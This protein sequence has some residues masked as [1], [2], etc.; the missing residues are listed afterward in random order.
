MSPDIEIAFL[1]HFA[2][3]L[4]V[5]ADSEV[6]LIDCIWEDANGLDITI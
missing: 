4:K 5:I 1:Q 2:L 6:H 3:C